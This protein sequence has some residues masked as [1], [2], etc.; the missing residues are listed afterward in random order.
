MKPVTTRNVKHRFEFDIKSSPFILFD[1]LSTPSGLSQ[2]FSDRVNVRYDTFIF[3]WEGISRTA[4]VLSKEEYKSIR[5]HW[6]D[7][8]ADEYFE[9]EITSTELTEGTV[10]IITDFGNSNELKEDQLLW[11]SQIQELRNRL[12]GL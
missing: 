7:S 12:G 6:E 8:P 11:E 4:K 5:F 9:F 3:Y 10:L 1:F 2:W